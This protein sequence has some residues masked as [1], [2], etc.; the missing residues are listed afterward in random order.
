MFIE[1]DLL[2]ATADTSGPY[3]IRTVVI[4]DRGVAE[5]S[6]WVTQ[7]GRRIFQSLPMHHEGGDVWKGRLPVLP[8]ATTVQYY[9]V[10]RDILDQK[11]HE[12]EG[13]PEDVVMG[14]RMTAPA[15]E[16]DGTPPFV[17]DPGADGGAGGAGGDGGAGGG[18]DGGGDG[19]AGGDEGGAGGGD[20]GAGGG[21]AGG[22]DG[23]VEGACEVSIEYPRHGVTLDPREDDFDP[24]VGGLQTPVRGVTDAP[25][26]TDAELL[27]SG[28]QSVTVQVQGGLFEYGSVTLPV[29]E[30]TLQVTVRAPASCTTKVSVAVLDEEGA[31]ECDDDGQ[32]VGDGPGAVC[33][34]GSCI[35]LTACDTISDCPAGML[36]HDSACIRPQEL[37]ADACG[38]D[39]D[40]G[41]DLI[42]SF[43]LCSP[44]TCRDDEDCLLDERCF[45]GECL[46][47]D[48][49]APDT[50]RDDEDCGDPGQQCL[51]GLCI[52]RQCFDDSDCSG[53]DN[54]FSGFCV[55]FPVPV[56][57]CAPDGSCPGGQQCFLNEVCLPGFLPL[58]ASCRDADDCDG[59]AADNVCIL[60][61]C[62]RADCQ[63][64]ADCNEGQ[65]CRFG[66]CVPED[67]PLPIPGACG[68]GRPDCPE[69]S[70]C[71][72]SICIPDA[73]PIP[74]P[75]NADGSCDN[76]RQQCLF[77]LICFGF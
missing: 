50:C 26:G 42:C 27:F 35:P 53:G 13:A 69:G 73:V 61:A 4:D 33:F 39:D 20:G 12:P 65:D 2:L 67:L 49:P 31:P 63:L 11:T 45:L 19:G 8:R 77:G 34:R 68:A 52:G 44:E 30:A 70:T 38:D 22:A 16:D 55:G 15:N 21:D 56:G 28:G 25:D 1:T 47:S 62:I 17:E 23:P 37:P 29:G 76:E 58:P 24:D 7:D 59:G 48:L 40:C 75:C 10:A 71:L 60:G 3:D 36:C 43:D 18:D 72:L 57:N 14:F 6:L 5:V 74:R 46:T 64:K 41:P 9:L 66:F 54:C 32:C 51:A